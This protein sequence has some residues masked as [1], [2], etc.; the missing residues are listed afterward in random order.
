MILFTCTVATF[1]AQK[2]AKNIALS[3][4]NTIQGVSRVVK[5]RILVPMSNPG[6][7]DQLMTMADSLSSKKTTEGL[8]VMHV[9]N[10]Q[11]EMSENDPGVHQLMSHAEKKASELG[12][13][14]NTLLR[15]DL[16]ITNGISA[17]VKEQKITDLI[18]GF[19]IRKEESDTFT[20]HLIEGVLS[21]CN[22]TT[23]I[24]K[25]NELAP[26]TYKR[27]RIIVPENAENELGFL[28]WLLKLWN[29]SRNTGAELEFFASNSTL[30]VIKSIHDKHPVNAQFREFAGWEYLPTL[31]TTLQADD[32]LVVVMSRRDKPSYHPYMNKIPYLLGTALNDRNFIILYPMQAGIEDAMQIDL[33]DPTFMEPIEKLDVLRKK[34]TLAL[35]KIKERL[36]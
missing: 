11:N 27:H 10:N 18:L 15:Y 19:H 20:G 1:Q 34:V 4:L 6:N 36:K 5:E 8:Y 23:F 31:L 9:M 25:T 17:M 21:K 12:A 32:N 3:E 2:G 28:F 33:K 24:V 29:I 22:T 35:K 7:V 14:A 30:Q 26:A 13:H 16:N